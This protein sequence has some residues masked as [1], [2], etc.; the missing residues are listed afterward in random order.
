MPK[1]AY[2]SGQTGI[3]EE[4]VDWLCAPTQQ[5]GWGRDTALRKSLPDGRCLIG[6]LA[7]G[8]SIPDVVSADTFIGDI[9]T[10]E[11]LVADLLDGRRASLMIGIRVDGEFVKI[12]Y[13]RS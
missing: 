6:D 4:V 11:Q 2:P 3:V 9:R 5:P 13:Y 7:T 8:D 12:S 1:I 10:L